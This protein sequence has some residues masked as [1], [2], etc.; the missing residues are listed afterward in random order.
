MTVSKA[1]GAMP[2]WCGGSVLL[3]SLS[4]VCRKRVLRVWIRKGLNAWSP[5]PDL[6]S[7]HC[8]FP[9]PCHLCGSPAGERACIP[10]WRRPARAFI[11]EDRMVV[12]PRLW[13]EVNQRARFHRHPFLSP[14]VCSVPCDS[15]PVFCSEAPC[16]SPSLRSAARPWPA[17]REGPGVDEAFGSL[18]RPAAPADPGS[19]EVSWNQIRLQMMHQKAYLS[20]T[21]NTPYKPTEG[22]IFWKKMGRVPSAYLVLKSHAWLPLM[23]AFTLSS[24][25]WSPRFVSKIGADF[26][27]WFLCFLIYWGRKKNL[28]F[29][30]AHSANFSLAS[31][32][33]NA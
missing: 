1:L 31:V 5:Q 27:L 18:P 30:L 16:S 23:E 7:D 8:W 10:Q 19:T 24:E 17:H 14:R 26:N 4:S 12:V 11:S 32:K 21:G 9:R 2:C 29:T 15:S 25:L 28:I 6:C 20:P 3:G 33:P 13:Q 22:S